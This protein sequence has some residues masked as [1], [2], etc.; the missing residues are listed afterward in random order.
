IRNE[1]GEPVRMLGAHNDVTS[2]KKAEEELEQAYR[3]QE[4]ISALVPGLVY[5][6]NQKDQQ[7]E[8]ANRSVGEMLGYSAEEI[9]EMGADFLPSVIHP[10]DLPRLALHF[11]AISKLPDGGV[12]TFEYRI[13]RP[14]GGYRWLS[15]NDSVFERDENG[16][17][18]RHI[19]IAVDVTRQKESEARALK[20][21]RDILSDNQS[22]LDAN[23][24]LVAVIQTA[25]SAI[26]AL[27][28]EGRIQMLNDAARHILGGIGDDLPLD[29][30]EDVKF[31][32]PEDLHPLEASADP[33]RRALA[34]VALKDEINLMSRTHGDEARYVRV[35]STVIEDSSSNLK[36]V[37][38][39]DDVSEQEMNRQ[40]VERAS[41][42]DALGQLTGG[43][44]HDFNNLL[45]TIHYA[46]DLALISDDE[47]RR[48]KYLDTALSSV[49]RG[50][51]L[52][53]RLMAF[54][55]RQPGL[56][57][58][59]NVGTALN[60]FETLVRPTIE[61]K[62]K[63]D[64]ATEED[65]LWVFCDQGQLENALLNLVL[66]SRDAILR[67]GRGDR[68]VVSAR[69]VAEINADATLRREDPHSY[70]SRG[71]HAEHAAER[72]RRDGR[73]FRYVELAVTDNGP[74]MSDEVKR[75]CIDPFFT[76]KN[77]NSGTGLGLSTVYGFV[78]QADGELRIYS[79]EGHGTTVR[80]LLPRGVE[81]GQRETPVDRLPSPRGDGQ[82]IMVVEDEPNL[83]NM[84][85]DLL[86]SLGYKVVRA[87][88]GKEALGLARG[89]AVF[90]LVLTDIV[91]PGGV[92]GFELARELRRVRPGLPVV[93]MSGYTGFTSEEMGDVV[94]PMIK[95]P[96]TPAE[97]AQTLQ[98]E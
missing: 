13:K 92:G 44:A 50:S 37:F 33:V 43:I 81:S 7:N 89:G 80:M 8:Y 51:T 47:E 24:L 53:Q 93:Y 85:E 48:T 3:F 64:F 65:G 96:C 58:S 16:E 77:T 11:N 52:T 23:E 25:A 63:V 32:H 87:S 62:I 71:M 41:R 57:K 70:I 38:V 22:L 84:M 6:Y 45:A 26:L 21:S 94:A 2:L 39:I 74:G 15:S 46:I 20:M 36:T 18:L 59:R 54:A 88:T 90:D 95:K 1:K 31:L 69:S 91:M 86:L 9:R 78:Q 4:R 73:V 40:Q 19:G 66:N 61:E 10:E 97:L 49:T 30:P 29:W 67:S 68:I 12:A 27:D 56:A 34:G 75:R 28:G 82:R 55:K 35:N 72:A 83:L 14:D 17:L 98:A 42:L 79:E 60:D 76:T 5:I